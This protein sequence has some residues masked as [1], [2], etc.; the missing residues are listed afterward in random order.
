MPSTI[1]KQSAGHKLRQVLSVP[2]NCF[3]LQWPRRSMFCKTDLI[4]KKCK[5]RDLAT[6]FVTSESEDR[7]MG[8]IDREGVVNISLTN[9]HS[10]LKF[11][12]NWLALYRTVKKIS[13]MSRKQFGEGKRCSDLM[14][15]KKRHDDVIKLKLFLR[16]WP[17]VRGIHRSPVNSPHK[18]QWH[19]V[20][21]FSLIFAWINGWVNN[22]EA[23]HLRPNLAYYDVTVMVPQISVSIG[24]D[25]GWKSLVK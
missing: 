4:F 15:K 9:Y 7:L 22:R 17:F 19:G 23:D 11:N 14:A 1:G 24:L 6:S 2:P 18:G 21:M 13:I 5:T 3:G 8:K 10:K 12:R 25:C 16:Y 20:L